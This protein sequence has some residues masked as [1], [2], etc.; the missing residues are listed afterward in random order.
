MAI[1]ALHW[2]YH[3]DWIEEAA[4]FLGSELKFTRL[5]LDLRADCYGKPGTGWRE[6]YLHFTNTTYYMIKHKRFT[7]DALLF[8]GM[9]HLSSNSR[10]ERFAALWML[11]HVKKMTED[12]LDLVSNRLQLEDDYRV[13]LYIIQLLNLNGKTA[14]GALPLL[15]ILFDNEWSSPH[16][17]KV[18]PNLMKMEIQYPY[19]KDSIGN[20]IKFHALNALVAIIVDAEKKK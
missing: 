20:I 12:D 18:N 10:D 4:N 2:T 17:D 13:Y 7:Q 11:K 6:R 14:K 19:Y 8:V 1:G 3:M 5:L 16:V 9:N 15:D